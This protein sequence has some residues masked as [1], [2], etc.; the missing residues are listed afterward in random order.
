MLH[1]ER[2]VDNRWDVAEVLGRR[3]EERDSGHSCL[4]ITAY[5]LY[6]E[7]HLCGTYKGI[8]AVLEGSSAIE[9]SS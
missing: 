2:K 8:L 6:L 1:A 3:F 4:G 9:I 7:N 5:S